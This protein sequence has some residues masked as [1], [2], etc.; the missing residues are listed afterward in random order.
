MGGSS[1]A[2]FMGNEK[3]DVRHGELSESIRNDEQVKNITQI[4]VDLNPRKI[5]MMNE[6]IPRKNDVHKNKG[7]SQ[8]NLDNRMWKIAL[9]NT[10]GL[11]T[12]NSDKTLKM[13][14]EYTK[15]EKILAMHFT[16]TWFEKTIEENANIEGYNIFRCDR[17]E[18]R[19]GVA[20]YLH[21]KVE[22]EKICE[23]R[24]KGC[25]MV[26][27]NIPELQTINIVVYRP[28]KTKKS[29]FDKILNEIEKIF[30]NTTKPEPTIILSGDF[31]FPF[32]KWNRMPSGACTWRYKTKKE[33]KTKKSVSN[34]TRMQFVKL[35][36]ICDEKCMLQVVEERTRGDNTL[37][38]IY[39]NEVNLVTDIDVNESAL[40]DHHRIE[41]STNYEIK[42]EKIQQN[43]SE[44]KD[45]MTSLNFHAK[46]NK[47]NCVDTTA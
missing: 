1:M 41:I 42:E 23:I 26:A 16:E 22:A 11:I 30:R 37:D 6:N 46:E 8:T 35:M 4:N 13:I 39:T 18:E 20:I 38:L 3:D 5:T 34:D 44:K 14:E 31:N 2:K 33:T 40:S 27:I 7:I 47:I 43:K 45:T 21:E 28:P 12:E 24:H 15:E 29:V 36:K 32:V 25:E 9:Q 19:G 17:K 10:R